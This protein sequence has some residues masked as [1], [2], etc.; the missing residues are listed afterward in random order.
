MFLFFTI[1]F[2]NCYINLTLHCITFLIRQ[3]PYAL[4]KMLLIFRCCLSFQI[5]PPRP[6]GRAERGRDLSALPE[7]GLPQPDRLRVRLGHG[8]E[9]EG[10]DEP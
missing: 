7:Q 6:D 4:Q 8:T 9:E 2:R 3:V 1:V 10:K 5:E